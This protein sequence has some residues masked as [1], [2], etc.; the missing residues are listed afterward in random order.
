MS[1]SLDNILL[2]KLV[3][4]QINGYQSRGRALMFFMFSFAVE[5]LV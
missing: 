3:E 2:L 4:N 5:T 1:V